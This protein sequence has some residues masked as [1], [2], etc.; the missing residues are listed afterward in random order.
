MTGRGF[1]R[2]LRSL[3]LVPAV[4]AL[5]A[6]TA[7]VSAAQS[8]ATRSGDA[9]VVSPT[10]PGKVIS[11]GGSETEFTLALPDGA[12][13]PGD[14]ANDDYRVQSFLVPATDDPGAI[15]W[16][17]IG[18]SGAGQIALY[19]TDTNQFA[20]Q[21]TEMNPGPGQPGI[22][23]PVAALSFATYAPTDLTPGPHRMGIACTLFN[24]T[25]N[26]WDVQVDLTRDEADQPAQIRWTVTSDQSSPSS[27][28]SS[29][30]PAWL[31]A[32]LAVLV[33]ALVVVIALM[34]RARRRPPVVHSSKESR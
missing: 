16:R 14:S 34:V 6:L 32:L 9:V 8:A 17:S 27:S 11:S 29:S 22:I 26:Y 20:Q 21:L 5:L 18:P 33:L 25:T 28:S 3:A 10:D 7:G 1:T 15:A 30:R 24:T 23:P 12:V 13:C 2:A 19:K 31:Y 4:A